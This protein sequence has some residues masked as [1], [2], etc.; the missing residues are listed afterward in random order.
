M[1]SIHSSSSLTA[2]YCNIKSYTCSFFCIW[3]T[4]DV[5]TCT[6]LRMSAW[7]FISVAFFVC[8]NFIIFVFIL[9]TLFSFLSYSKI[10]L[11]TEVLNISFCRP[12]Q[13]LYSK[14]RFKRPILAGLL[15]AVW[16]GV[17][18]SV[19]IWHSLYLWI[20]FEAQ[21]IPFFL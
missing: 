17:M 15:K 9:Y 13:Y 2:F 5:S 3:M 6:P 21:F 7:P 8:I 19:E 10:P 18:D 11:Y 12:I 1:L 4:H 16:E 14:N 20:I